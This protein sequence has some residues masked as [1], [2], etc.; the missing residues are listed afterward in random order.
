[1]PDD[2]RDICRVPRGVN[3]SLFETGETRHA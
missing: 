1:M 3:Q 2:A